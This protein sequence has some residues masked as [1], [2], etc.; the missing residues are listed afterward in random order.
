MDCFL[1]KGNVD[2]ASTMTDEEVVVL[3]I[4]DIVEGRMEVCENTTWLILLALDVA[5]D[6][7][8][9]FVT[10]HYP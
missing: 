10:I 2:A 9:N 4:K 8:P 1:S 6:G 5:V 7:R 3:K